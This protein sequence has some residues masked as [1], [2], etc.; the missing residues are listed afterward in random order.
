MLLMHVDS[1]EIAD[2]FD[3]FFYFFIYL[4]FYFTATYCNTGNAIDAR[5]LDGNR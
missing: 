2:K 5:R 3:L 4:F 1:T